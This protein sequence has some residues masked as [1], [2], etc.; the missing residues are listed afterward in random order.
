D[1]GT[2]EFTTHTIE[3]LK[4][5]CF[6]QIKKY[7]IYYETNG[8]QTESVVDRI[9][10]VVCPNNCSNNGVCTA[11]VCI[12][13]ASFVGFDCSHTK[14]TPPTNTSLPENGLC[15]TSKRACAKTNIYGYFLEEN[16]HV[17]FNFFE[18]TDSGKSAVL[19]THTTI[20]TYIGL[21]I[22]KADF[23]INSRRKRSSSANVYG[24]GFDINLSYDGVNYGD[25]M[26]LIIYNDEC[27]NCNAS[28]FECT[29]KQ[30]CPT[31]T[32]T[33]TEQTTTGARSTGSSTV[34]IPPTKQGGGRRQP[35]EKPESNEEEN[36]HLGLIIT[37]IVLSLLIL[38]VVSALLYMK[39]R[40]SRKS[41]PMTYGTSTV[42]CSQPPRQHYET[43]SQ[44]RPPS[45]PPRYDTI[46]GSPLQGSNK[47]TEPPESRPQ[48]ASG[49]HVDFT[50]KAYSNQ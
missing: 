2:T 1:A 32:A 34:Q 45:P 7:E 5:F 24:N 21:T 4:Q 38:A 3:S 29:L 11:G 30:S 14:S 22:I 9:G 6:E 15:T 25:T 47:T 39:L 37:L 40:P 33:T 13:S 31:T 50:N 41:S 12:C 17:K 23:P 44:G 10:K 36:V 43:I 8:T 35:P 19:S 49:I 20:G 28:T 16:I 42:E 48:T 27:F 26:T 46:T 18:I